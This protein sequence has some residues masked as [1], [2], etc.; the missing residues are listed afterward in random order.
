MTKL[1][2]S[3]CQKEKDFPNTL[4]VVTDEIEGWE[5]TVES[6]ADILKVTNALCENC[7]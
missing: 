6:N 1:T 2:C 3:S 7:Q 4:T 5:L